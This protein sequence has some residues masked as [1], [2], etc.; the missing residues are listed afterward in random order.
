AEAGHDVTVLTSAAVVGGGLA[1]S[2]ADVPLRRRFA[3]A[4]GAT[5]TQ[6]AMLGWDGAAATIRSTLTGAIE[7]LAADAVV[8]AETPAAETTLAAELDAL[9]VPFHEIGD[10]VAPR[11]ASLAIH[12]GRELA[13]R[14]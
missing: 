11:R 5:R 1:H 10:C 13:L 12:D 3:A 9:G 6:V 4:N 7:Q 14:L 8:I 2:A